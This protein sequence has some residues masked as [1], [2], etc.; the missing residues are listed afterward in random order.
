MGSNYDRGVVLYQAKKYSLSEKEFREEL[1]TEPDSSSAHA[2]LSMTLLADG[3]AKEARREAEESVRLDPEDSLSYFVLSSA[4]HVLRKNKEALKAIDEALRLSPDKAYILEKASNIYLTTKDFKK[5]LTLAEKALAIDPKDADIWDA[6]ALAHFGL[7]QFD[8]SLRALDNALSLAPDSYDSHIQMAIVQEK[9][10]KH[11]EAL[12][13][14]RESLR[15]EPNSMVARSGVVS[16]LLSQNPIY[17]GFDNTVSWLAQLPFWLKI[18]LF[19]CGAF[20]AL[21]LLQVLVAII[22]IIIKSL[23]MLVL[24]FDSLGRIVLTKRQ[25][26]ISRFVLALVILSILALSFHK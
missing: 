9:K 26:V 16:S 22:F 8:E 12:K 17:R 21:V 19:C 14:F 15:L 24:Q 2:M 18:I 11:Q 3:R 20:Q 4:L 5:A 1:K 23:G 13:H 6:K 10:G 7:N 25:V